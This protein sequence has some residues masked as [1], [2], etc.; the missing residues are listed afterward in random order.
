MPSYTQT[1]RTKLRRLAKRASY[2][3]AEVHAILDEAFICHIGFAID[4]QP[5]VIPTIF[6]RAGDTLYV[7]GSAASRMLR[8]LTRKVPVCVTVTLLDGLV[9]ARSAFHHSLNYRSVVVLGDAR[10][11]EDAD[12]KMRALHVITDHVVPGR[13]REVR[14]P[15]ELELKQSSV[16]A[17]RLEEVSAKIRRGPPIDD[18]P[19]Y[20]LPIWAGVL[21]VHTRLGAPLADQRVQSQAPRLDLARFRAKKGRFDDSA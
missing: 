4:A 3:Q 8:T 11:V 12:E 15:N 2:D 13:W 14:G 7:H 10:L 16:L 19:D 6:A 5:Y 18:E 1:P 9:L 20:A 21:P 17:V